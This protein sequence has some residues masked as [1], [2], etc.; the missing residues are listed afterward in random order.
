VVSR[1]CNEI[2]EP[3]LNTRVSK[4]QSIEA[5]Q[6]SGHRIIA[7]KASWVVF[8]LCLLC[9]LCFGYCYKAISNGE[10]VRYCH[11]GC[12]T[13]LSRIHAQSNCNVNLNL[14]LSSPTRSLGL[15]GVA[16]ANT[17]VGISFYYYYYC[18]TTPVQLTRPMFGCCISPVSL[19]PAIQHNVA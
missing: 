9:D 8:Q 4:G 16:M 12:C 14:L 2:T 10:R 19:W 5:L 17:T 1:P 6:R 13:Y 7:E 11:G 3:K 18:S 15:W